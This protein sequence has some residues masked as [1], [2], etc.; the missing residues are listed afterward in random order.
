MPTSALDE[1]LDCTSEISSCK[2]QGSISD[3]VMSDP[4]RE[5]KT[6]AMDMAAH[7]DHVRERLLAAASTSVNADGENQQ[8]MRTLL[9]GVEWLAASDPDGDHM[10]IQELMSAQRFMLDTWHRS[11]AVSNPTLHRAPRRVCGV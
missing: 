8:T 5:G 6:N 3:E 7:A 1:I 9:L 2:S 10:Q 4:V 11:R